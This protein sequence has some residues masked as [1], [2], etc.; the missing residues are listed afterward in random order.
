MISVALVE[1]KTPGNVGAVAR[2]MKNFNLE[3]LILVN[4]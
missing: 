4:P 3:R 1:P 2:C